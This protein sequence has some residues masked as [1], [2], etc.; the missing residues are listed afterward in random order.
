MMGSA[1]IPVILSGGSGTRLWPLSRKDYPK[2]FLDLTGGKSLF[3][4]TCERVDAPGFGR[5]VILANNDHRFIVAEQMRQIGREPAAIVLE[6]VGRNTAPAALIA[7]LMAARR[8][9]DALVLLLPSD[10]IIADVK[11]F[12][13]SVRIGMEAARTGR[14]VT[15]G[16]KPTGAHTGYGYIET[17]PG[18]GD[19]LDVR[20]FVEK[21]SRERAEQYLRAGNYYW[22][23]GIFLFSAGVMIEAFGRYVPSMLEPCREALDRAREDLDFLRLD[24]EAYARCEDI[25]IDYAIMERADNIAC[26]PLRSDWNDLGSW[27]AVAELHRADA[28]GNAG[29]G[30]VMFNRSG[31][32]F[33]WSADDALVVVNGLDDVIVTAT[34][35]VVLVTSKAEAQ[36]VGEIVRHLKEKGCP[37]VLRHVRVYRPWGWFE[38]LATGDRFR[39]KCLM[40]KPGEKLSLQSHR[41]RAEHWVV[42]QGMACVTI[43]DRV[44]NLSVDQSVYIPVGVKHRLENKGETPAM[45]IEVQTGD[46]LGEDDIIRYVD[47]YNRK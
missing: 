4:Q 3:Q 2:Q 17:T 34:R 33:A 8:G 19:V 40:V 46:Y 29:R 31:N 18:K 20:R 11:R 36:K 42:V 15:F 27:P 44:R 32:C 41:H 14:F 30:N 38:S 21:P 24:E 43:G 1:I 25:S 6:P 45:L 22:N 28:D 12:V 13:D 7:A 9:E 23:A 26:V 35:D 47:A 5:P 16:V 37:S 39:V 10:Q